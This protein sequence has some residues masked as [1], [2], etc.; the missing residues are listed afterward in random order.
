MW[1]RHIARHAKN[2]PVNFTAK[3]NYCSCSKHKV[4]ASQ[5][6]ES[7]IPTESETAAAGTTGSQTPPVEFEQGL[8]PTTAP[9]ASSNT[10][11]A[12]PQSEGDLHSQGEDEGDEI[13]KEETIAGQIHREKKPI[14]PAKQ[15]KWQRDFAQK[16]SHKSMT[17]RFYRT[18][19]VVVFLATLFLVGSYFLEVAH[20]LLKSESRRKVN[21]TSS[22]IHDATNSPQARALLFYMLPAVR[23][24]NVTGL[25]DFRVCAKAPISDLFKFLHTHPSKTSKM[26]LAHIFFS[27]FFLAPTFNSAC[28][29]KGVKFSS[30]EIEDAFVLQQY[31]HFHDLKR[32]GKIRPDAMYVLQDEYGGPL[33]RDKPTLDDGLHDDIIIASYNAAR[34][35]INPGARGFQDISTSLVLSASKQIKIFDPPPTLNCTAKQN[36]SGGYFLYFQ[37]RNHGSWLGSDF[38]TS[39]KHRIEAEGDVR[40]QNPRASLKQSLQTPAAQARGIQMHFRSRSTNDSVFE[41]DYHSSMLKSRFCVSP[42]GNT[43]YTA[44]LWDTLTFGC[45]PVIVSGGYIP[46]YSPTIMWRDL[47]IRIPETF[48]FANISKLAAAIMEQHDEIVSRVYGGDSCLWAQTLTKVKKVFDSNEQLFHLLVNSSKLRWLQAHRLDHYPKHPISLE[49]DL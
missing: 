12:E 3:K 11:D 42:A 40:I 32:Q 13:S 23:S 9:E 20:P 1:R 31:K 39:R 36:S 43:P 2:W 46:P 49:L 21:R 35:M 37:G 7:E 29:P 19:I 47:A 17:T 27:D 6:A 22:F 10:P 48:E 38:L 5:T 14:M 33:F 8:A 44:R 41:L 4:S 26:E 28:L 15:S 25:Q 16:A 45:I 34:G 24:P 30:R 18:G